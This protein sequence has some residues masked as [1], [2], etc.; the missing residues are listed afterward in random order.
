MQ[1]EE[2]EKNNEMGELQYGAWMRGETV[3]RLG[4]EP[5]YTKKE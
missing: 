4:W 3:R 5:T 1:K 2:I